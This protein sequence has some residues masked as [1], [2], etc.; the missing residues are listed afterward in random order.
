[1]GGQ[2]SAE[3]VHASM[4][5]CEGVRVFVVIVDIDFYINSQTKFTD[6][7]YRHI[8]ITELISFSMIS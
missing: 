7:K 1:M 5:W 4:R 8:V 2:Q 6:Y 3:R